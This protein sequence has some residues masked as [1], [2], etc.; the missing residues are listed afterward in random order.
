MRTIASQTTFNSL[1]TQQMYEYPPPPPHQFPLVS[2]NH[3]C[4][5]GSTN[6]GEV[7]TSSN[8]TKILVCMG[9]GV[10]VCGV[11][12]VWI[13][14]RSD[15]PFSCYKACIVYELAICHE[16]YTPPLSDHA[17]IS[18]ETTLCN[19]ASENVVYWNG[20]ILPRGGGG[21][22]DEFRHTCHMSVSAYQITGNSTVCYMACLI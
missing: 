7:M 9:G 19:K 13:W 5:V 18:P 21:G 17:I 20:A 11:R 15:P 3:Q 4:L 8:L 2:G 14:W 10:F 22:G 12:C 1:F 16:S 6:K